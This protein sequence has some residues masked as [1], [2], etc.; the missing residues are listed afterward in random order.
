MTLADEKPLLISENYFPLGGLQSLFVLNSYLSETL[1][2][3]LADKDQE[4]SLLNCL[5]PLQAQSLLQKLQSSSEINRRLEDLARLENPDSPLKAKT[6]PKKTH[7]KIEK[8]RRPEFD[9][10][11]GVFKKVKTENEKYSNSFDEKS[12]ASTECDYQV[13]EQE[14]SGLIRAKSCSVKAKKQES[15]KSAKSVTLQS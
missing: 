12:E 2:R 4:G 8:A 7:K 10:E 13:L 14:S 3:F 5:S 1:N 15:P 9:F 11:Y 6:S